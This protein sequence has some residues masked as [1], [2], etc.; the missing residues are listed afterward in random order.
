MKLMAN[1]IEGKD[2][3]ED[4]GLR[5]GNDLREGKSQVDAQGRLRPLSAVGGIRPG[6]Y[7]G[8]KRQDF[9]H[10]PSGPFTGRLRGLQPI[11][12]AKAIPS[13]TPV[14]GRS[15]KINTFF[16]HRPGI[17][18]GPITAYGG[19]ARKRAWSRPYHAHSP[20][21]FSLL[22]VLLALAI[23]TGAIAVLGELARIGLRCAA[24]ARDL[25]QAQLLC[26]TKL[27]EIISGIQ[28]PTSVQ[29]AQ[30]EKIDPSENLPW[31]YSIEEQTIDEEGLI[32]VRVT[33]TQDLPPEKHPLSFSLTQWIPDPSLESSA[34][35]STESST[36]QTEGSTTTKTN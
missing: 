9:F 5:E 35:T 3:C 8:R 24:A 29:K 31:V 33:V 27:A 15:L 30:F 16:S 23:L 2:E 4:Q 22:E 17:N 28:P 18:A 25:T 7:A 32:A 6:V 21:G 10:L 36:G 13:R 11:S 1:Q 34:E 12:L 14:N 20:S 19:N 26:E